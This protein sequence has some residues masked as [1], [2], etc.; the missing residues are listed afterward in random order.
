[1]IQD[2]TIHQCQMGNIDAQ[3]LIYE[4][5]SSK[6]F[7]VVRRYVPCRAVAEDLLHDGFIH[8]FSRI[9]DFRGE[10]S[11]EGWSRRIFVTIT[12]SYLRRET[13]FKRESVDNNIAC[14]IPSHAESVLQ[15]MENEQIME[16]IGTLPT[17]QR[18]VLNL[19]SIE[20]YSHDEIAKKID[21]TPQN[22]R[23][24]LHRAKLQLASMLKE[25]EIV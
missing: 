5:L 21:I 16:L 20:G 9:N 19:Y 13:K 4:A 1:M 7:F 11:F 6:M 24:I 12:L 23:I 3:R 25:R 8:L 14:S 18:T 2:E 17:I 22:S 15:T 10:G